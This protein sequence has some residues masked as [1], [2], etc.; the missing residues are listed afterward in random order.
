MSTGEKVPV[1]FQSRELSFRVSQLTRDRLQRLAVT[2]LVVRAIP[3]CPLALRVTVARLGSLLERMRGT[4]VLD[5]RSFQ[6]ADNSPQVRSPNRTCRRQVRGRRARVVIVIER[7]RA[8]FAGSTADIG[9]ARR[10]FTEPRVGKGRGQN[11]SPDPPRWPRRGFLPRPPA[12][13]RGLHLRPGQ[14]EH[15]HRPPLLPQS[16]QGAMPALRPS[17]CADLND[18]GSNHTSYTITSRSPRAPWPTCAV[19][20]VRSSCFLNG[21]TGIV[22]CSTILLESGETPSRVRWSSDARPSRHSCL[23]ALESEQRQLAEQHERN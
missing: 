8:A 1:S 19:S 22:L 12:C 11:R 2:L 10:A 21:S 14:R 20:A 6:A 17:D 15:P 7:R 23:A 16:R 5:A 18:A 3:S 4:G 13:R 9:A